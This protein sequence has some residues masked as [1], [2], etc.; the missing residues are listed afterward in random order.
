MSKGT[1][2]FNWASQ[3]KQRPQDTVTCWENIC[4]VLYRRSYTVVTFFIS[5]IRTN[6]YQRVV[7][8][9][10]MCLQIEHCLALSVT[11]LHFQ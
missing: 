2:L 8:H 3:H 6:E 9:L 10:E 11:A 7:Y 4:V 1:F 5:V